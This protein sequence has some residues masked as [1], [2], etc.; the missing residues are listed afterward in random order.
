MRL[1]PAASPPIRSRSEPV[2]TRCEVSSS[3]TAPSDLHPRKPN[4]RTKPSQAHIT[5]VGANTGTPHHQ[6]PL[7]RVVPATCSAGQHPRTHPSTSDASSTASQG[8]GASDTPS[9]PSLGHAATRP[10]PGRGDEANSE[11][12]ASKTKR[13]ISLGRT[14]RKAERYPRHHRPPALL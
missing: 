12:K 6:Q 11:A 2:P 4:P 7:R 14:G 8:W 13:R 10:G 1:S 9:D 3:P 5:M